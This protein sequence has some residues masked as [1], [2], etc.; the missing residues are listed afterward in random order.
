MPERGLEPPTFALQVRCTTCCATPASRPTKNLEL[1]PPRKK[2]ANKPGGGLIGKRKK[3][4]LF[5][6][7]KDSNPCGLFHGN[8]V[9]IGMANG[10]ANKVMRFYLWLVGAHKNKGH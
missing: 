5:L 9:D 3:R 1:L 6:R 2:A 4:G 8:K 10:M 7:Q